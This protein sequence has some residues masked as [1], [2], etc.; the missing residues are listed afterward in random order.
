MS[1]EGAQ[2]IKVGVG[3][4]FVV[5]GGDRV[6]VS[7]DGKNVTAD[8]KNGFEVKAAV[9]AA[10][11]GI[12]I[13]ADFNTVV[14]NGVTIERAADGHLV[15]SSPGGI[16][17]QAAP[18]N[19]SAAINAEPKIGDKM[20]AGHPHAGW[21]YAGISKTTHEP[22][23]VAPK[24][25][26][27]FQ[28][29]EAMAFAANDGSRVPSQDELDQIYEARNKGALK[30][31]FNVTGSDSAGWYWSARDSFLIAWAQRF[32]NGLQAS[33]FKTLASSLRCVR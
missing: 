24:D 1:A 17:K 6:E 16:V 28:W 31:T 21:I 23:Y 7:P 32:S 14:L 25:S 4:D 8:A 33:T 22:F 26:G 18:A 30:G 5:M 10:T 27:V 2:G 3:Q 19:D 11:Q 29:K 20:Q 15:I 12:S 13:S 9:A